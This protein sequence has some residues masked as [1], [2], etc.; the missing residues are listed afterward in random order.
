M[1]LMDSNFPNAVSPAVWPEIPH[2]GNRQQF[3]QSWQSDAFHQPLWGREENNPNFMTPEN[4]LL[5]Y[6]S[7]AN[8]GRLELIFYLSNIITSWLLF[9][10]ASSFHKTRIGVWC[11]G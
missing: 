5:S 3:Q 4:S 11:E 6:D 2:N 9:P 1:S 7:S 10:L 8:S